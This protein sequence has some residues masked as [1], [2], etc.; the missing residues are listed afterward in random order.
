MNLIRQQLLQLCY[1]G[2]CGSASWLLCPRRPQ[3]GW[4]WVFL[5]LLR[6]SSLDPRWCWFIRMPL[7]V[8][9]RGGMTWSIW[10]FIKQCEF[11]TYVCL[12]ETV[13]LCSHVI[14]YIYV[15]MPHTFWISR[16]KLMDTASGNYYYTHYES[17]T[18]A[19]SLPNDVVLKMVKPQADFEPSPV[20][21]ICLMFCYFCICLIFSCFIFQ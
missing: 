11:I 19:W 18:T 21:M 16:M 12:G 7:H 2:L 20:S 10:L 6:Q 17:A 15:Y 3:P 8:Y 4:L 14:S 1:N 13:K 9:H 5:L